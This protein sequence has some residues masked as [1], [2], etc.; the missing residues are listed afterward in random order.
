MSLKIGPGVSVLFPFGKRHIDLEDFR[1]RQRV[2]VRFIHI[3]GKLRS[4]S[5]LLE[6]AVVLHEYRIGI[7]QHQNITKPVLF[8]MTDQ[9][10]CVFDRQRDVFDRLAVDDKTRPAAADEVSDADRIGEGN[11]FVVCPAGCDRNKVTAPL[12]FVQRPF[13]TGNDLVRR[14]IGQCCVDV[15]E[16]VFLMHA[17]PPSQIRIPSSLQ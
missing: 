9:F 11:G 10:S 4:S 13:R 3:G 6:E 2:H 14:I 7:I 15:E 12:Q 5:R 17:L 8:R 1:K 16:K